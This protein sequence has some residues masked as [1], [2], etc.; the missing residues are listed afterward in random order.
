MIT[1][2]LEI[3]V[4]ISLFGTTEIAN[5]ALAPGE[6]ILITAGTEFAVAAAEGGCVFLEIEATEGFNMNLVKNDTVFSLKEL[7]PYEDGKIV[8]ADI[9][10][11]AYT[12]LALMSFDAGTATPVHAAP[13]EALVTCLE[14]EG[15]INDEGVDYRIHAGENFTF[16]TGS[17]H[18]VTAVTKYKMTVLIL[19][20][21]R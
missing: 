10:N 20:K 13:G 12:K 17:L 18:K 21:G 19:K 11:N 8:N 7:I 14:G 9:V 4:Y 1:V 6:G 2:L 16:R 3:Y 15:I 5:A